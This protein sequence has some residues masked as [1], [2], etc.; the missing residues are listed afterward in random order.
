[1]WP[2]GLDLFVHIL[3]QIK[4]QYNHPHI[5]SHDKMGLFWSKLESLQLKLII[6]FFKLYYIM[7]TKFKKHNNAPK[8]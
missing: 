8:T 7:N 3:I 1:M 4:I 5:A 6:Y 2:T